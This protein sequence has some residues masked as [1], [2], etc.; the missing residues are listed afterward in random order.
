VRVDG[1]LLLP[2]VSGIILRVTCGPDRRQRV[3]LS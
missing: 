1:G 2:S 3:L